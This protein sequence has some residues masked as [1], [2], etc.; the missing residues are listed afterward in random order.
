L[1]KLVLQLLHLNPAIS[2]VLQ[3]EL[4]P[5]P[6]PLRATNLVFVKQ[7]AREALE[8][9]E[10]EWGQEEGWRRE[11]GAVMKDLEEE[12]QALFG[13]AASYIKGNDPAFA[14]KILVAM[15]DG[16][17][18]GA[19]L[20]ANHKDRRAVIFEKCQISWTEAALAVSQLD[21]RQKEEIEHKVAQL[22]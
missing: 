16:L 21:P 6:T 7:R 5:S 10:L 22:L 11:S 1:R 17:I 13:L 12:L 9:F 15:T 4:S 8:L 14:I 2:D 20:L 19:P 18:E 3:S